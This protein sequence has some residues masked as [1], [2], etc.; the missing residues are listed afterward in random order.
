MF[1]EDHVAR[2]DT[3]GRAGCLTK[4]IPS[5]SML[6]NGEENL[7]N[8][9]RYF[10]YYDAVYGK[11]LENAFSYLITSSDEGMVYMVSRSE[12]EY[13]LVSVDLKTNEV[14]NLGRI[15][16]N[17]APGMLPEWTGCL[18]D[19]KLF[20]T[21]RGCDTGNIYCL[22]LGEAEVIESI[23]ISEIC[24]GIDA[25]FGNRIFVSQMD[26]YEDNVYLLL[27]EYVNRDYEAALY[28]WNPNNKKLELLN[29]CNHVKKINIAIVKKY[30]TN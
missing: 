4:E 3:V 20:F 9:A 26:S 14:N 27:N 18:L 8:G 25:K 6:D 1:S 17:N 15:D 2:S 22:N 23:S 5:G 21:D 19:Q 12:T 7:I 11:S 28:S 16:I 24:Q 29:D 30:L 10:S 13:Y